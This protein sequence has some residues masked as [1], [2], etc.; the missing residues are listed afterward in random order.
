MLKKFHYACVSGFCHLDWLLGL[1]VTAG[2]WHSCI[3][4]LIFGWMYGFGLSSGLCA[5][6][7]RAWCL[8]SDTSVLFRFSFSV[9]SRHT[10]SL[11][12][13]IFFIWALGRWKF[14]CCTLL[15]D[16]CVS[17]SPWRLS[18]LFS[19]CL[20]HMAFMFVSVYHVPFCQSQ[21]LALPPCYLVIVF[22][23]PPGLCG[24]FPCTGFCCVLPCP[25]FLACPA[26]RGLLQSCHSRPWTVFSPTG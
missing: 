21:V 15:L 14:V 22:F 9:G 11:V 8:G 23:A 2:S 16:L 26:S 6:V 13:F 4:C 10:V 5:R 18:V 1:V 17:V 7:F 19:M 12:F 20:L 24:C 25:V 3:V